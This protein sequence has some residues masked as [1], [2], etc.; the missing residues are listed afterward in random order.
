MHTVRFLLL[1]TCMLAGAAHADPVPASKLAYVGHWQ[2]QDMEITLHKDGKLLYKRNKPKFKADL[3]L[4][5]SGFDGNDFYAGVG[6]FRSTFVV[7]KPPSRVG[8]AWT[9]SV[10]GVELTK[11]A[12]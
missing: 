6:P 4:D 9:M 12:Q 3:T 11:Q 7:S 5:V 1:A 10:D 8:K 2:G